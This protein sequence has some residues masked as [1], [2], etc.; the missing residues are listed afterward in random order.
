MPQ[1]IRI[2]RGTKAQLDAY[3]SLQQ[4]E[5]GFCTDTK[6]VYIG[7]G[8]TNTFVGRAMSGTLANRP[9]ASAAGRFY[10]ATDDGYLYLDLGTTWVRTGGALQMITAGNGLTGGGQA[11]T[12]T[13][14]VGAGNGINVLADTVEVKAYRGITVDTNGVA[15]N[16]DGSSIVYDSANGNR[17]MVAVIDGGTF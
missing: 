13:L 1:T 12:V 7:D 16:I 17:L 5:M 10:F 4:G 3:G 6:E 11:D 15:V 2:K 8:S 9:N 14:H